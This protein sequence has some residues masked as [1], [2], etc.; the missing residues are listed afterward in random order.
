LLQSI[1]LGRAPQWVRQQ[2]ATGTAGHP[3]G[4]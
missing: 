2:G 1:P 4:V 3:G